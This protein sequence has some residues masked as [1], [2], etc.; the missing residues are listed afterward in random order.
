MTKLWLIYVGCILSLAGGIIIGIGLGAQTLMSW[1]M[2]YKPNE[3]GLIVLGAVAFILG[4]I[5]VYFAKPS[6]TP[7]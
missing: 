4:I 1:L 2:M 6:K 5:A 7:R 3:S